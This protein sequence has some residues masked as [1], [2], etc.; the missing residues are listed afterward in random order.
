MKIFKILILLI[1]IFLG[2]EVYQT[3]KKGGVFSTLKSIGTSNEKIIV[4]PPGVEDL[5]IDQETGV[6]YLSSQNRRDKKSTGDIFL[7]NTNDTTVFFKNLTAQIGL[8]EFRPHG[9]SFLKTKNGKKFL[10]VV[11]HK[12]ES[13]EVI[14]FE[15]LKDSLL[16]INKFKSSEFVSPNDILAIGENQFYITNDHSRKNDLL[17]VIGDYIKFPSGNVVYFDGQ[18]AK[19]VSDGIAYAN[20]INL[21]KDKNTIFVTS[22]STNTLYAFKPNI[23][24][25][26]LELV[27]KHE[28]KFPP[29]NIELDNDGTLFIACHPKIFEFTAHAKNEKSKSSSAVITVNYDEN[30]KNKFI[31][32]II[33]VNNG[34]S[35]SGS[36]TA[37]PFTKAGKNKIL[38]GSVFE[39]KILE[40][41]Q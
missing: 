31:E 25:F 30:S 17:R 5:T 1:V 3:L 13:S 19:I 18:K 26:Q 27:E 29:D 8:S 14:K 16:L 21:S 39:N 12:N 20:G 34:H 32:K 22:T 40:V 41:N 10:F 24:S 6:A 9:L 35:L 11:S 36:S 23:Q 7:M 37:T 33:Y 4:S 38:I 15:I 28:T 2:W